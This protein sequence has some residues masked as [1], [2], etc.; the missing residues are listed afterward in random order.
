M[1]CFYPFLLSL[2]AN[3]TVAHSLTA[4]ATAQNAAANA[5]QSAAPMVSPGV[6]P[7]LQSSIQLKS[8]YTS[9]EKLGI[10]EQSTLKPVPRGSLLELTPQIRATFD[11]PFDP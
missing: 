9:R 3:A 1:R 4:T 7:S 10:V 2:A 6:Q 8:P 5:P 11:N